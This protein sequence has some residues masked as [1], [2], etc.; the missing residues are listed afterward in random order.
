MLKRYL[1]VRFIL[2]AVLLGGC[3]SQQVKPNQSVEPVFFPPRPDKPRIQ[4]LTS[5]NTSVDITGRRTSHWRYVAGDETPLPIHKPYGM[6]LRNGKLYI[7]DSMLP[8]LEIIDLEQ[9]HFEYF[10]PM[11]AGQLQKPLNCTVDSYD[12]IYVADASRGQVMVYNANH[13][14]MYAIGKPGTGRPTDVL[15]HQSKIWVCDVA[16][17]QVVVYDSSGQKEQFRFPDRQKGSNR[18]LFSP[19]NIAAL[20]DTI[21]VTDTGDAR[22]KKYK[23]DG[24]FLGSVGSFGKK[25]GAFVRPKGIAVTREGYLYVSDAA[26]ENVQI[27]DAAGNHRMY[28]GGPTNMPGAMYLPAGIMIDYEHLNLFR[29]YVD[30]RFELKY[31]IFTANQ[32]GTDKINIYG[33]VEQK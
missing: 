20:N 2:L 3:A 8:G 21:Y 26:F 18:Y 17:H 19:T 24:T 4:Y 28:F 27:F 33:Y 9:H 14:F 25:P 32:Y 30:S 11:T 29:K 5:I 12:R 16:S 7:C 22:V 10:Q 6:A 23:T 15:L 31:L 13:D 1:C